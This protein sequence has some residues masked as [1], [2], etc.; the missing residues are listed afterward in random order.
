VNEEKE[1]LLVHLQQGIYSPHLKALHPKLRKLSEESSTYALMYLMLKTIELDWDNCGEQ[2]ADP[3]EVEEAQVLAP[4]LIDLVEKIDA[5]L[6][7]SALDAAWKAFLALD[8]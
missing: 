1:S 6:E 5:P 8:Y 2:G 7:A 4:L 3:K